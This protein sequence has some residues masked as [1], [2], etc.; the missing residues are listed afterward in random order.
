M[1]F[2]PETYKTAEE[3]EKKGELEEAWKL[4]YEEWIQHGDYDY[5]DDEMYFELLREDA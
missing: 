1:Y 4:L 2:D 3:L 5:Y